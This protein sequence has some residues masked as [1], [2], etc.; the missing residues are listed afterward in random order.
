MKSLVTIAGALLVTASTPTAQARPMHA[1]GT[2][3]VKL[4]PQTDA[5]TTVGRMSIDKV[6]HGDIDGTSKGTMLALMGSDPTSGAYVAIE[7]I[8]GTLH[9]RKGSFALHHTGVMNRGAQSLTV[10]VIPDSGTGELVGIAGSLKI[11]IEGKKHSYE[12]DYTL[13]K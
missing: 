13:P 10:T 8:T 11:I 2:F 12:F 9:G 1:A 5:D 7:R 6:F 3:D 4:V